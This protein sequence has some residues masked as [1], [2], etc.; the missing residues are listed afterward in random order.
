M[1]YSDWL[2]QSNSAAKFREAYSLAD[3]MDVSLR[4]KVFEAIH[5]QSEVAWAEVKAMDTQALASDPC[6]GGNG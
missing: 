6:G 3:Q 4:L 5:R 2:R 1:S